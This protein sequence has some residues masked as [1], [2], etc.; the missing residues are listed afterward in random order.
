MTEMLKAGLWCND[1]HLSQADGRWSVTGDP[2][3]GALIT[4]A[5]KAT[6][7]LTPSSRLDSIPFD[8]KHQFMATLHEGGWVYVK[9]AVEL[10]LER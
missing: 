8:S 2:T 7:N 3:E 6:M 4:V 1:S 9:G 10:L 5:K